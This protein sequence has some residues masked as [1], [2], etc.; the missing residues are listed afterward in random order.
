[1]ILTLL[2]IILYDVE[3]AEEGWY[4]CTVLTILEMILLEVLGSE[5]GDDLSNDC[6]SSSGSSS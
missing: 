5:G 1:M 3:A 4:S 2:T 6:S